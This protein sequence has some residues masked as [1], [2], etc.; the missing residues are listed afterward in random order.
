[1]ERIAVLMEKYTNLKIFF[2]FL[3]NFQHPLI[4]IAADDKVL[5][6]Y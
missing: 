6:V 4:M 5:Q 3:L 2:K 1:M